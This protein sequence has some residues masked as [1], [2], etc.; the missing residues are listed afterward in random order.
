MDMLATGV[1]V[2]STDKSS[3]NIMLAFSKPIDNLSLGVESFS[4]DGDG[5]SMETDGPFVA[6]V[7]QVRRV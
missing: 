2:P 4:V 6:R 5:P 3:V 7:Q 1:N